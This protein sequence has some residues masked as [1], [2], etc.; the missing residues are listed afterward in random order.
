[1]SKILFTVKLTLILAL[2]NLTLGYNIM[3]GSYVKDSLAS[4]DARINRAFTIVR[5]EVL[6]KSAGGSNVGVIPVAIYHQ[7]VNGINYKVIAAIKDNRNKKVDLIHSIVYT[8]PFS[9]DFANQ[10]PKITFYEKL[11]SDLLTIDEFKVQGIKAKL[12]E[13][14]NSNKATLSK[15]NSIITY[16]NLVYEESFFLVN[17]E[18]TQGETTS[19]QIFIVSQNSDRTFSIL[20]TVS[21][22]N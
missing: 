18:T 8:G 4:N 1:M 20:N 22:F 14:L 16:P 9:E 12:D 13:H 3:V 21:F 19:P 5:D 2:F 6:S 15:I 11:P 10:T 17:A 7:I